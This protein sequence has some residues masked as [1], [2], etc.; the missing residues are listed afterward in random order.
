[1]SYSGRRGSVH[2]YFN[3]HRIR[4]DTFWR[5][6][7]VSIALFSVVLLAADLTY[8]RMDPNAQQ[9]ISNLFSLPHHGPE[10]N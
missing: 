10:A 8:Y 1:M 7:A 2:L 3:G 4:K 6:V 5:F 9:A